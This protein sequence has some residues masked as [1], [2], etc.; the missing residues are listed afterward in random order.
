MEL[1]ELIKAFGRR[2][3]VQIASTARSGINHCVDLHRIRKLDTFA[4]IFDIG[5]HVGETSTYYADCA[6]QATIF[7][8][9]PVQSN[10]VQLV[11][12]AQRIPRIKPVCVALGSSEGKRPLYRGATSQ[13]HSL[14]ALSTP[15][16]SRD[17]LPERVDVTTADAFASANH[18][19]R[20]D[21][22]K[23]DT[24]GFDLEVLRGAH[25]L[26]DS[27]A[28]DF[29]YSEVGFDRND[30]RHTYFDDIFQFLREYQFGFLGLYELAPNGPPWHLEYCNALFSRV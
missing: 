2:M 9:E 10:F 24:E 12:C 17:D 1:R 11:E 30:P 28:I 22:L 16:D 19:E 27:R 4:T 29:V 3:G 13:T 5:A 26:L 15:N 23:T 18:I 8:F 7:S 14:V 20:I 6:R 25:E 21:L